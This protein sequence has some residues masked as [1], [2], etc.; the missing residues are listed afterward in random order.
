MIAIWTFVIDEGHIGDSSRLNGN[1]I[2]ILSWRFIAQR[3]K[4]LY[5]FINNVYRVKR[6]HISSPYMNRTHMDL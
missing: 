5:R 2:S 3:S 1:A 4:H 6:I